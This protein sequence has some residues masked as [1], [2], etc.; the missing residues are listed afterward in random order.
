MMLWTLTG[1]SILLAVVSFL[2]LWRHEAWWVRDT[3]F[4]RLQLAGIALA[5]LVVEAVTLDFSRLGAWLAVALTLASLLY[6]SWWILPYSPFFPK[7]VK[8]ARPKCSP[9]RLICPDGEIGRHKGLK[10]PRP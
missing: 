7:E 10:I 3:D 2:S 9:Q 1:L 5:L 8:S 4:P 6:Q